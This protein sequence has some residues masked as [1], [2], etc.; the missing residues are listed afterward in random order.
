MNREN[1]TIGIEEEYMICDPIS[2]EMINKADDI[3]SKLPNSL[4]NRFSYELLL[5]EIESNTSICNNVDEVIEK[6]ASNRQLLADIGIKENYSIGVSGTHPTANPE[7]QNFVNNESYNWV[8]QNLQ[9]YARQN[10]TFALHVH[11]GFS[12][13][14]DLIHVCNGLRRW[15]APLLA[16]SANSPF[17][18]SIYT[19][20][21]SSR[22]IQFGLFPRTG[23]PVEFK[24]YSHFE[25]IVET[26]MIN[27]SIAKPRH[28]W[29]KIR[30]HMDFGTIEFRMFDVQRSFDNTY[31]LTALSQALCYVALNEYKKG[32]LTEKFNFEYL[33]DALW[34]AS[35]FNIDT[36]V[37]D[38]ATDSHLP[39]RNLILLML[40]YAKPGLEYFNNVKVIELVNKVLSNG[41][42][43]DMQYFYYK[44]NNDSFDKLKQYLIKNVEY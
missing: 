37:Y 35:R 42:E 22:T 23:I 17:F 36:I 12:N 21:K 25:K 14:E 13:N 16:L 33:D 43:G 9:Y 44:N 26:L 32:L 3:I 34:K 5:S 40:Q 11:I 6:I 38:E 10:I 31:M 4:S 8:S 18:N 7:Q 41:T 39:I 30:P 28:L 15:I 2:G 20:F 19:G 1:F 24:S 29:W 27:E